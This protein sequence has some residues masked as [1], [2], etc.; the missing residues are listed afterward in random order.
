MKALIVLFIIVVIVFILFSIRVR[1]EGGAYKATKSLKPGD[2]TNKMYSIAQLAYYENRKLDYSSI[3][4]YLQAH[5]TVYR[6]AYVSDAFIDALSYKVI[7]EFD[8]N[9]YAAAPSDS[10]I[11]RYQEANFVS[12]R[13]HCVTRDTGVSISLYAA[14]PNGKRRSISLYAAEEV[15]SLTNRSN[16]IEV[17]S[18]ID[19]ESIK[20]IEKYEPLK[21]KPYIYIEFIYDN[22]S[23]PFFEFYKGIH[24]STAEVFKQL[25]TLN[26]DVAIIRIRR[27]N[28]TID[29]IYHLGWPIKIKLI[30][31]YDK[32]VAIN[33]DIRIEN[34]IKVDKLETKLIHIPA[35]ANGL[36]MDEAIYVEDSEEVVSAPKPSEQTMFGKPSVLK[37]IQIEHSEGLGRHKNNAL[38]FILRY[39]NYAEL[40]ADETIALIK[41][42][43]NINEIIFDFKDGL[44]L[45]TV[46]T[47][48]VLRLLPYTVRDGFNKI[49][50]CEAL[51]SAERWPQ[52]EE[53]EIMTSKRP[54]LDMV[55]S[56][57][58]IALKHKLPLNSNR[59]QSLNLSKNE[60]AISPKA[61][62]ELYS[63]ENKLM[64][65]LREQANS[66]STSNE[67]SSAAESSVYEV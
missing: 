62:F 13:R 28:V 34:G 23:V 2:N 65:R 44:P 20:Y 35:T 17:W 50:I 49:E 3:H 55:P 53:N 26:F 37:L 45:N 41:A 27:M 39:S 57:S 47:N 51:T 52:N 32:R 22:M 31:I 24:E 11:T 8:E 6:A 42:A 48:S 36:F 4:S 66:S 1:L 16:D 7:Y 64:I 58:S 60:L 5:P 9:I 14:A 10:L 56:V 63:F 38:E 67:E 19:N 61:Q 30:K 21:P 29:G 12:K 15:N 46:N 33:E 54:P 18:K 59:I 43:M 40:N 25:K